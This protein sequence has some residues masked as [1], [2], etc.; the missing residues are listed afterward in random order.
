MPTSID[1]DL[2]PTEIRV[3]GVLIE[4]G[5]TT[6]DY[7]PLSLNA[8]TTG[9]NQKSNRDPV[10]DFSEIEVQDTLDQLISKSLIREKS[11]SGGRVNKYAHRLSDSLGL[12]FGLSRNALGTLCVLMLRGPQTG[13]EIRTRAARLCDHENLNDVEQT[14]RELV[15]DERGPY[16][17]QLAREPG[18]KE[19]RYAQLLGGA[20][21]VE[22]EGSVIRMEVQAEAKAGESRIEALEREVAALRAEVEDLKPRLAPD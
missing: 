10:T 21:P 16:V 19:S 14:L 22:S 5:L 15:E 4:K 8:V 3:L 12:R 7:Y 17:A 9:C 2:T 13:G 6:P 1:F 18:R 20:A 11:S